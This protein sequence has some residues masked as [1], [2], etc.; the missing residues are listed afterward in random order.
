MSFIVFRPQVFQRELLEKAYAAQKA[1]MEA[2]EG[3]EPA[4]DAIF[5]VDIAEDVKLGLVEGPAS[6]PV[7][8]V[9]AFDFACKMPAT[10]VKAQ[11]VL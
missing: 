7:T 6:A 5:A 10:S 3:R 9:K 2:E 11:I 1:Q 8:I 4:E